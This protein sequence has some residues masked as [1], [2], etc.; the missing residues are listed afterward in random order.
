M[1][2]YNCHIHTFI[3]VDVPPNALPIHSVN[4]ITNPTIAKSLSNLFEGKPGEKKMKLINY[5]SYFFDVTQIDT[6]KDMLEYAM[7]FYP[8]ETFFFVLAMD[9]AYM[10]AGQVKR[11]YEEQLEELAKLRRDHYPDTIIPFIGVDPRRK[12]ILDLVK[13]YV[14]KENFRGIKL[15]PSLGFYPYDE[16]LMPV[17][18]YASKNN[19]PVISHCTKNGAAH[20]QG[21]K[22]EVK[23]LLKTGNYVTVEDD[24]KN[25]SQLV[26]YFIHP[27]NYKPILEKF[28]H[29][30]ICLAHWGGTAQWQ[31]FFYEPKNEKEINH[32]SN[33]LRIINHMMTSGKYKNLFVDISYTTRIPEHYPLLKTLLANPKIRRRVLFG[34]DFFLDQ[35]S[36][37]EREFGVNIRGYLGEKLFKKIA[38]WNPRSF[39]HG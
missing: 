14:E 28:P 11:P 24:G 30:K 23:E 32:R 19:L 27:F 13:H 25:L 34:S 2:F 39:L 20:F 21:T 3:N 12:N 22:K 17:Y 36:I 37:G 15:Y 35:I 5:W 10:G 33:W 6:Q 29:L 1:R 16:R 38:I 8:R 9:M 31:K 7:R 4:A 18:E 26:N